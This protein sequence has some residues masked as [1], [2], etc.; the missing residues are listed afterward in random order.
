VKPVTQHDFLRLC[1]VRR[2]LRKQAG[3]IAKIAGPKDAGR[4]DAQATRRLLS[5]VTK[6]VNDP[7]LREVD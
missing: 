3:N 2:D 6:A 5:I 4:Q 7:A 1:R